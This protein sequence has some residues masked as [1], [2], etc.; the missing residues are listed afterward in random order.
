[1]NSSLMQS[2]AYHHHHFLINHARSNMFQKQLIP[3]LDVNGG[4]APA[5]Y[6]I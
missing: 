4:A 1:M 2:N 5:T 6:A 3:Y